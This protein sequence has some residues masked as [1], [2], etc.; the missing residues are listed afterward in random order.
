MEGIFSKLGFS[1]P[2]EGIGLLFILVI[3]LFAICIALVIG[4]ITLLVRKRDFSNNIVGAN[5]IQTRQKQ[6]ASVN[7]KSGKGRIPNEKVRMLEL[8]QKNLTRNIDDIYRKIGKSYQKVGIVKYNAYSNMSGNISFVI[9]MLDG[10]NSGFILNVINGREGSNI[11]IKDINNA[12]SN[13]RLGEEEI[14]ALKNAVTQD[15]SY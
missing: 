9:A 6:K 5:S 7:S 4:I 3:I 13:E 15:A 1:S 8:R 2:E 12:Q 10:N 11:Y 14:Q